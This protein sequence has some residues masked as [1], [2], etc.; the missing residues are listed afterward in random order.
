M[1]GTGKSQGAATR[2]RA[3]VSSTPA[4]SNKKVKKG[5]A[6]M[7]HLFGV[8]RFYSHGCIFLAQTSMAPLKLALLLSHTHL[9]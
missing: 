2:K 6:L 7:T 8:V 3:R 5:G 9:L 4:K 1:Q